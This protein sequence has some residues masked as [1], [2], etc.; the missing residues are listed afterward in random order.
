M[1][2]TTKKTT[3]LAAVPIAQS[4]DG[5]VKIYSIKDETGSEYLSFGETWTIKGEGFTEATESRFIPDVALSAEGGSYL[6]DLEFSADG[7]TLKLHYNPSKESTLP[8]GRHNNANLGVMTC[9]DGELEMLRIPVKVE[10]RT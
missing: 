3:L 4:S 2:T 5:L 7:K 8:S 10:V 1:T 6:F 9:L